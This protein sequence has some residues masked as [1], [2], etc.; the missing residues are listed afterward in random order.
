MKMI[1]E[2]SG[3]LRAAGRNLELEQSLMRL[4]LV[5][6]GEIYTLFLAF[7]G[8]LDDGLLHPIVILG[9]IYILFSLVVILQVGLW[10]TGPR[11]RHTT[12]MVF[13]IL[14]VCILLYSLGELGVPFFAVYLW[15]TVGNGFRYGY[16]EL[17]LC[18]ILSLSGFV[19]VS[20]LSDF[21]KDELLFTITGIILLSVIPLYVAVMLK[22]LQAEKDRAEHASQEKSRFIANIS[23]EIR[24]PLNAIVGFSS[25]LNRVKSTD[26][27]REM[28]GRIREASDSLMD[29]VE[30]VLDF[31]R[32]EAGHVQIRN[33]V[34]DLNALLESVEG[35]FSLQTAKKG[36]RYITAL[37]DDVPQLVVGDEQRLRQI[38][39]NLVG[40]AVKFTDRGSV[41]VSVGI[42]G[43]EG[44]DQMLLFEVVD[45]GQGISEEFQE[46]IF[47]RFRQADDSAQRRYSGTG[48]GTTIARNL[49]ELMGG[50]I[51][52][53]SRYGA[54]SRFWFTIPVRRP[55]DLQLDTYHAGAVLRA[56]AASCTAVSCARVLVVE[57]S[58]I[59]CRV[60][61]TMLHYLGVDVDFAETGAKALEMLKQNTYE[62]LIFDMQMPGMSGT[63]IIRRYQDI[64]RPEN[65]VPIVVITGD[66][67]ADIEQE[68]GELGVRAFLAKPV[69]LDRMRALV[70]R[71][72]A[73]NKAALASGPSA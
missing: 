27:Q 38:L 29:L 40:N 6:C 24:T 9:M 37:H 66:A 2:L 41:R 23:H 22:R 28:V 34:V 64:T 19:V 67:T 4:L 33:R 20:Q 39:V 55:D 3:S 36:V 68:C 14:L 60:Y 25:M 50:K 8:K 1:R 31:S 61:E 62:L 72:L 53:H 32:I 5:C 54:G 70:S 65:R 16:E 21:W 49:V 56:E 69:S 73:L 42:V 12:Y 52:V 51:G 58:D 35:M 47:D 45:T 30:G 13:D 11:W 46:H 59:N 63:E 15:L 44:A 17:I 48:L 10:P 18:A 7:T 57:D 71:F 43:P 26:E